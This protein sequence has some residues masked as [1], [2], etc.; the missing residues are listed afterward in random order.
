L[1]FGGG[2]TA[3]RFS[4]YLAGQAEHL[5][6]GRCLGP[7]ALGVYGRAYQLMAGP[8]VLFGNVLDRVLFPTMVHV[9]N[10]PK[11]LAEAYRRGIALVALVILPLSAIVVALAP[12]VVQ[13]LLGSDWNAVILPLQI[14]GVGMLFRTGCKI[15]DSLVRATGAVYRRTWRQTAYALLVLVGALIGQFWGVEGV[16]VAVLVTLAL[17]FFLMA[18][19]ALRLAEMPWRTFA[20]AHLPG[21]ALAA[22][23]GTPV[24]LAAAG[25]RAWDAGP[26]TVL[27]L[28]SAAVV[29]ALIGVVAV[30]RIFLG[31]DGQWMVRKLIALVLGTGQESAGKHQEPNPAAGQPIVLLGRRLAAAGVRYCRWKGHVDLQRVLSGAGDLDL[32]VDRYDADIF[33]RVAD[34]LGFKQVVPCFESAPA[35]EAHLYGLDQQTGALLHVHVNF[36][37]LGA[38]YSLSP[39]LEEFVM[40]NSSPDNSPGLLEGMPVVQPQ[41]ELIAFVM[42]AMEQYAR[43][44]QYP[45][46][47]VTGERLQA[48]LQSLLA[49]D[50]AEGWRASLECWLQSPSAKRGSGQTLGWRSGS[51]PFAE[52]LTA[53][54]QPTSWLRRF[55]L[56]RR[57]QG[58][59]ASPLARLPKASEGI[60]A[61]VGQMVHRLWHGHGSPKK[62][63]GGRQVIAFVGPDASGKSTMVSAS[64]GWLGKVFRVEVAH[65][66]KPP[67]TWLTWLPNVVGKL[68]GRVAPRMRTFHQRPA[69]AGT[70]ARGQ[71][72]LYRLRAVLLAWDRRALALRLARKAEQGW[73]IICDRY[74]TA[75]V[76]APDSAR[77]RAP[78]AEPKLPWLRA[79]LARLENRLYR[80]IP[81][82][83]IVIRLSAPLGLTIDRNRERDKTGKEGDD[84]IARRHSDFFM[85]PFGDA[86]IVVL[87]TSTSQEESIQ[88]M[89]RQLWQALCWPTPRELNESGPSLH[90]VN[91]FTDNTVQQAKATLVVEFIGVTGVGKSTLIAAVLQALTAQGLRAG[92]AE[93][94]ILARYGVVCPGLPK[95]QSALVSAL[96]L[97]P[98]CRYFFTRNGSHL[99]RMAFDS[100]LRG[101]SNL[102][103][104]ANLL[105]NFMKRIGAHFLL[106]NLRDEVRDFDVVIWDEGAVHA[107]HN[108]FV[109]HGTEPRTAEI[110]EFGRVVPKPDVLVWVTAPTAQSAKVLLQRGH[111]RVGATMLAANTF[112]AH[113]QTT[114]ET[115]ACV[116]E[117]KERI[118]RIDN[119]AQADQTEEAIRTRAHAISVF[120]AA[121]LEQSQKSLPREGV[122]LCLTA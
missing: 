78:E 82:P 116:D 38:K 24:A 19:L 42:R 63:P 118:Y 67:S 37:L 93:D 89:R 102:W 13:I 31:R 117:L 115:L 75:C 68:L 62:L 100:I 11:R 92:L 46:L 43:L 79:A 71:G 77:L 90:L 26:L 85:P 86:Q 2:F 4:N 36:A 105:R 76:G 119:S 91:G 98:F 21:L 14:L 7:V 95:V 16:A 96:S 56:A 49:A 35:Q 25:L 99:S 20:A 40:Q 88:A 41:A 64:A 87:D 94:V 109:H 10:E 61:R 8:A 17:N 5:V 53:L 47:A 104:G 6:I 74:P 48:K 60:G 72:L 34:E 112:A 120:L 73:L 108:L 33:L 9:Q 114:F 51:E 107:A 69:Q 110:E 58:S 52:F 66:G 27:L 54:W 32:L 113:A 30:P 106:E 81:D 3:S 103:V 111:S 70:N 122:S 18:Q 22:L 59:I 101:M 39:S 121:Q 44:G 65:L 28:S 1:R 15:S 84:F 29:P 57:L 97:R 83:D 80:D 45:R 50:T 23:M 55:R 12:E